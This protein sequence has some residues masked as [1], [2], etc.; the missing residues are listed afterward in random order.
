MPHWLWGQL[1]ACA[2]PCGCTRQVTPA[3][4]PLGLTGSLCTATSRGHQDKAAAQRVSR[5]RTTVCTSIRLHICK[6]HSRPVPT[7]WAGGRGEGVFSL[8][9]RRGIKAQ[10]RQ[11][12]CPEPHGWKVAGTTQA[13]ACGTRSPV[14]GPGSQATDKQC[15]A[16]QFSDSTGLWQG[17]G[18]LGTP[19]A[20]GPRVWA[21]HHQH[22]SSLWSQQAAAPLLTAAEI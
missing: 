18:N 14:S 17:P 11:V 9:S 13:W 3:P 22:A 19:G 21:S 10:G 15:W 12:V 16:A 2:C 20:G 4:A 5:A 6:A 8:I 7:G 1:R